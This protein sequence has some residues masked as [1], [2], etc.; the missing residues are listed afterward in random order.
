MNDN[1]DL[2]ERLEKSLG[3]GP[4]PLPVDVHLRSGRRA[5]LRRRLAAGAAALAVVTVIGTGFALIE[6]GPDDAAQ[7]VEPA[8]PGPSFEGVE[9]V[10]AGTKPAVVLKGD[11]LEV[12]ADVN[13]TE[14]VEDPVD[15]EFADHSYGVAWD[16]GGT[17]RWVLF[18]D[19][20]GVSGSLGGQVDPSAIA[21]FA[22]FDAW[23]ADAVERLE[24]GETGIDSADPV[25][26]EELQRIDFVRFGQ[27][28]SLVVADPTFAIAEQTGEVDLPANFAGPGDRTAAALV[29][30]G[31]Y[32]LVF[33]LA[34]ELPDSA[35][36]YIAYAFSDKTGTS[37]ESFLEFAV[38]KY[39]S[40]EGL[41]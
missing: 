35:P 3:D 13:L 22:T 10:P 26:Q 9:E 21:E 8:A 16:R 27:G 41:R 1:L 40:G 19:G 15:S 11:T 30:A 36:E 14:V 20:A 6:G 7:V 28:E 37:L 18:H 33:V 17:S 39:D 4:E 2:A 38:T 5:L 29:I 32:G 25:T 31:E 24:S 23:L 12:A 34:R